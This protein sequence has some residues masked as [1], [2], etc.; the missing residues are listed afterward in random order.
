[1]IDDPDG[2][3]IELEPTI[4]PWPLPPVAVDDHVHLDPRESRVIEVLDND[5]DVDVGLESS[6]LEI[7]ASPAA[8]SARVVS[9]PSLGAGDDHIEG[10]AG[11]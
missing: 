5:H 8:G 3:H 10:E 1:M 11:E 2:H 6:T 9:S 4:V 7:V